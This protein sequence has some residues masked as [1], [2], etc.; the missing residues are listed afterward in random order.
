MS[1]TTSPSAIG[2][3]QASDTASNTADSVQD[4]VLWQAKGRIMQRREKRRDQISIGTR[5]FSPKNRL[6][7]LDI[8]K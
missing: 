4:E 2:L 3:V 8:L 5:I 6:T 7:P 1:L